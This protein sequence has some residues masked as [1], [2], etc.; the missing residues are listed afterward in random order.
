MTNTPKLSR[1]VWGTWRFN[2]TDSHVTS[3]LD[4]HGVVSR[5]STS[6]IT[7]PQQEKRIVSIWSN[8][9]ES[10]TFSTTLPVNFLIM[11]IHS[12]FCSLNCVGVLYLLHLI[13]P[14]SQLKQQLLTDDLLLFKFSNK[15]ASSI[16]DDVWDAAISAEVNTVNLSKNTLTEVPARWDS[17]TDDQYIV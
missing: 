14:H 9:L 10:T 7:N 15:K 8:Q 12:C 2:S 6:G 17:C 4:S 3:Q 13:G 11:A 1:F 16:P 5:K